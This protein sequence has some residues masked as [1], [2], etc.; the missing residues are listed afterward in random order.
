MSHYR[1]KDLLN[2]IEVGRAGVLCVKKI[3]F[4]ATVHFKRNRK[5]F[6]W[7]SY[8]EN[9]TNN[10]WNNI[11][12][13]GPIKVS[14]NTRSILNDELHIL[15]DLNINLCENGTLIRQN[16]KDIVNNTYKI[17]SEAKNYLEFCKTFGFNP[18]VIDLH[19]YLK[20]HSSAGIFQT[21]C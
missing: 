13:A 12:T 5:Y 4:N 10:C 1:S 2:L 15:G 18:S 16:N 6:H 20:C 8:S 14:R 17:S 9:K 21:F 7:A 19:L 11:Q 3:C